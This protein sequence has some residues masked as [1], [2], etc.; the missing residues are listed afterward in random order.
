MVHG[1]MVL[2][3]QMQ[4]VADLAKICRG[5]MSSSLLFPTLHLSIFFFF[6][7]LLPYLPLASN[8]GCSR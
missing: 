3:L 2:V 1:P 7:L 6:P 5:L 8:G 4:A